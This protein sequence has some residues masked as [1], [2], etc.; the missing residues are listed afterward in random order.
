MAP[1]EQKALPDKRGDQQLSTDVKEDRRSFL[2][3]D[4]RRMTFT[5]HLAEL[6]DRI[7]RSAIAVV[8]A[9]LVCYMFSNQLFYIVAAPLGSLANSDFVH[10]VM[11]NPPE[12]SAPVNPG[13]ENTP[14]AGSAAKWVTLSPMEGFMVQIKIAGYFS[15][16]LALPFILYNIAAFVFPGLKP[17]ERRIVQFLIAGCSVLGSV[18]VIIAYFG[19]FPL[20]LPYL[21]QWNPL[22]VEQQLRM[23]ETVSFIIIGL[24]GFA[25][26]FQFPMGVLVLVYM[27]LLTPATLREYRK[28]AVIGMAFAS[29]FFTPPDPISMLIMLV[30][31]VVLYEFSILVAQ[32]MV[33]R[34]KSAE[35][36]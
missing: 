31:L 3:Y 16:L 22:G 14:L 23:S 29:A 9:F 6:R 35:T 21:L 8:V 10:L 34:K 2:D 17:G 25:I 30:P 12:G 28:I 27:G 13:A 1:E 15:L 11:G 18:G 33:W 19:I 36:A 4:D 32:M 5:E 26:A 7:I 24:V 20:V